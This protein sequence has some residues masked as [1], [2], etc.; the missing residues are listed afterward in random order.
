MAFEGRSLPVVMLYCIGEGRKKQAAF[1]A[2]PPT[3]YIRFL[4][5]HK[6]CIH[7]KNLPGGHLGMF[8]TPRGYHPFFFKLLP[9]VEAVHLDC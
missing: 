1:L 5:L 4:C 9:Y 2:K 3:R 7:I 6:A 8:L